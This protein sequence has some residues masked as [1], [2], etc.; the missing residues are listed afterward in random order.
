MKREEC[1]VGTIVKVDSIIS[2]GRVGKIIGDDGT[3]LNPIW[4]QF[5]DDVD[6]HK[7]CEP[8]EL[9]KV[10]EPQTP[11]KFRKGDIV[12]RIDT[13]RGDSHENHLKIGETYTVATDENGKGNVHVHYNGTDGNSIQVVKWYDLELVAVNPV[14]ARVA[15]YA[16]HV[17]VTLND[18]SY[19]HEIWYKSEATPNSPYT[20]EE[21]LTMAQ[22]ICDKL[23]NN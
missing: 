14:K 20:E 1:K 10:E 12:R 3:D 15:E 18:G 11:R 9:T 4:V 7:M 19:I 23:N 5:L 21:A 16:G 6:E 17:K 13:G 22:E 8:T 2:D